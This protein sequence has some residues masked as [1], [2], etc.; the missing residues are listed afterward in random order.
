[1]RDRSTVKLVECPRDAMQ[2]WPSIIPTEQKI[3]YL[4][5]LLDVG[6]DVLD[7]G[8]FVSPKAIPQMADTAEV[9]SSLDLSNTNTELLAIVANRKGVQQACSYH[10]IDILGY[11]FSVSE[12]FQQRNTN[13]SIEDALTMLKEVVPQIHEAGKKLVVYISMGFGNPYGDSYSVEEVIA[14]M[15]QLHNAGVQSFSL[16]DTVGLA[17]AKQVQELTEL[18]IK[19]FPQTEIGMHL[20]ARADSWED[21]IG[22]A[23]QAGCMRFDSA[24]KG[25]GGCPMA[26]DELVGNIDTEELLKY[27]TDKGVAPSINATALQKAAAIASAIFI[28]N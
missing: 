8:S 11:P 1:M 22:A 19:E 5:S 23:L 10:Q 2:G 17:S 24:M 16:A 15:E 12:T 25:I 20:H 18:T 13:S 27:F 28:R 9:L 7:F 6:F 4:Q 26:K 3:I 21:K 14:W